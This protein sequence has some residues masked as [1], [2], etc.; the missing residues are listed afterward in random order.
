M[1]IS[2]DGTS[3]F[4]LTTSTPVTA[5]PFSMAIWGNLNTDAG[6]HCF[7]IG[8]TDGDPY[9]SILTVVTNLDVIA[10]ARSAAG[11]GQAVSAGG[12]ITVGVW[13]HFAAVQTTPTDRE[14]FRDGANR[15]ANAT[16]RTPAG[17][18][19]MGIGCK[20]DD[21][22]T[23][24]EWNGELF[25]AALWDSDLTDAQIQNLG[26]GYSPL[27]VQRQNLVFFARC[28]YTDPIDMIGFRTLAAT[29][30]PTIASAAPFGVRRVLPRGR[31]RDRL[32][33]SA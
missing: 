13:A 4:Y 29:G 2:L 23:E 31:G 25:W 18:D 26:D 3:D 12:G 15:G 1:A 11:T 32:R 27:T 30:T 10:R 20:A 16:D 24:N 9:F 7:S 19:R 22:P 6:L 8:D 17:I 21:G 28:E 5:T 14:A 33:L